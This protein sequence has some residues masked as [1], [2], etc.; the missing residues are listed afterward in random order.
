MTMKG[1]RRLVVRVK[2]KLDERAISRAFEPDF[3]QLVRKAVR[4]AEGLEGLG[5]VVG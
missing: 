1:L 3:Y 4:A 5:E 2:D